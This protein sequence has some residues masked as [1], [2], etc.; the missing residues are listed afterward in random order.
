MHSILLHELSNVPLSF[1]KTNG[2]LNMATKSDLINILMG[3]DAILHKIPAPKPE[4]KTCVFIDE[5]GKPSNCRTFNEYALA[6][7]RCVTSSVDE[8]V[9]ELMLC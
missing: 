7:F 5:H 3:R 4:Q 8:H 2:T 9:N 1:A 6:F